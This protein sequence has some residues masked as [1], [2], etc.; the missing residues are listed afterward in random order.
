MRIITALTLLVLLCSCAHDHKK[1]WKE[2]NEKRKAEVAERFRKFNDENRRPATYAEP[3]HYTDVYTWEAK[4]VL[5]RKRSTGGTDFKMLHRGQ[6]RVPGMNCV[7]GI[8]ERLGPNRFA[9]TIACSDGRAETV[10]C[11][12][13]IKEELR[14][15]CNSCKAV[16]GEDL[17]LAV[18]IE[19]LLTIREYH[20]RGLKKEMN[21]EYGTY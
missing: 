8:E 10:D 18:D 16:L 14:G 13:E 9:R 20:R 19:M 2:Y 15:T 11:E 17:T 5:I 4:W 12:C 3:T 21:G 1:A 7:V 6:Y